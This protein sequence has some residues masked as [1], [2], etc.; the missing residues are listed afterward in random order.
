MCTPM[1]Q[2]LRSKKGIYH[3]SASTS[4]EIRS[5]LYTRVVRLPDCGDAP[6]LLLLSPVLC[7]VI[8]ANLEV[9]GARISIDLS[10]DQCS[11]L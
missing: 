6:R 8:K 4:G 10:R 9:K 2:S 1:Q 5:H 3:P 7:D 11:V